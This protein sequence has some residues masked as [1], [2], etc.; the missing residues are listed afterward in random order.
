MAHV[1]VF[2]SEP[3]P[4]HVLLVGFLS[5]LS[6]LNLLRSFPYIR[7][8]SPSLILSGVCCVLSQILW[9]LW[10]RSTW[11]PF[12]EVC[13]FFFILVWLV[14]FIYFI[15][16]SSNDTALPYGATIS[17]STCLRSSFETTSSLVHQ[18]LRPQEHL[19]FQALFFHLLVPCLY[20]N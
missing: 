9:F 11:Y 12:E 10:L 8:T 17:A 1:L 18:F 7:S 13:A 16:I 2:I 15:S 6:Y 5:H 14:P 3:V 19:K 4:W 20:Q